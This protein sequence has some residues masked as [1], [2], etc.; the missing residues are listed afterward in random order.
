MDLDVERYRDSLDR[1]T[2]F[3]ALKD[4]WH[5]PAVLAVVFTGFMLRYMPANG[6]KYLQAVDP[7]MIFRMSQ[8][9]ALEGNMPQLDFMR[10]FPYAMPTYLLYPGDIIVPSLLWNAGFGL[11]FSSYLEWAQFYPALLGA[12][13]VLTMYFLG[14]ELFDRKAGVSA[15]FF[16]AVLPGAL[17]RTSAGFFEK[18][19]L[20]TFCMMA[21]LLF[22]TR[23]WKKESWKNGILSGLMLGIFTISWGG[24]RMLWLLYPIV[25]FATLMINEDTR[26]LVAAYTPTV[27]IAGF[28]ATIL[29]QR[30]FSLTGNLFIASLGILGALWVRHLAE[31]LKLIGKNRLPHLVPAISVFGILM[32][33]LSPLYSDFIA[34][35]VIGVFQMAFQTGGGV[36]AGTVAENAPPAPSSLVR[37]LGPGIVSGINPVVDFLATVASPWSLMVYGVPFIATSVLLMVAVKYNLL[38]SPVKGKKHTAFMQAGFVSWIPFLLSLVLI[39]FQVT[40]PGPAN[41]VSILSIGA[42]ASLVIGA[43]VFTLIYFLEADSAF[44]IGSLLVGGAVAGALIF[45]IRFSSGLGSDVSKLT[46]IPVS[47]AF[48]GTLAMYYWEP[49]EPKK[50]ELKW[51][52]MLPL[53][54]VVSNVYGGTTRSRL[55]FLSTFS[56][57]LAAGY[58]FR[59]VI[60]KLENLD[61]GDLE[62]THP[63]NLK[64]AL[65]VFTVIVTLGLSGFSGYVMSQGL[66]GSPSPSPELWEQSVDFMQDS[67]EGSVILSWWDY[68]YYFQTLGRR[69]SVA[70]GGQGGYYTQ[71]TRAVNMPL[72]DYLNGTATNPLDRTF[73]R[74]HSA[75]YIWLDRS[76]IG[77]FSA[78]SQISN[79]D[80]SEYTGIRQMSTPGSL[81]DSISRSGNQ[82][83]VNF[84]G[85]LGR[86]VADIYTPVESTNT[87]MYISGPPTVRYPNGQTAQIDCVLK[88]SGRKEFNVSGGIGFCAAEGPFYSFERS[89]VSG[90]PRLLLVPD[91]ISNSTFVRLYIQDGWGVPYAEKVPEASNSY[92]KMW[93]IDLDQE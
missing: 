80:N 27:L 74:K 24:A 88:E 34:S 14:K 29:A 5:I 10:Y 54:W 11:F 7:Y 83:L 41:V 44:S 81:R 32:A 2:V 72:A 60:M 68:G 78:V 36:I 75:D 93:E 9:Y 26:S 12:L 64:S 71:E 22:F 82:T 23:A 46:L 1:E 79:E 48:V 33:I 51:F 53:I 45:T 85:R 42:L 43:S 63:D 52:W 77:K 13:S 89:S 87:S 6:M 91:K 35:K 69:P 21:S 20:G 70:D 30:R 47:I 62:F 90:R 8:H 61:F 19:P 16:L 50:I 28:F 25:V 55:V 57:A 3:N 66:G 49:F 73:L 67:P 86:N 38:S 76:M 65:I 37:S 31:E 40:T 56:M 59:T 92:I 18:E 15:A 4:R 39:S 58:A 17:R 84:R